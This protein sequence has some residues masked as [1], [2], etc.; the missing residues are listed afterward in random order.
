VCDKSHTETKAYL[1][2][3]LSC[4]CGCSNSK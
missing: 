2:I 1:R 3:D 4:S